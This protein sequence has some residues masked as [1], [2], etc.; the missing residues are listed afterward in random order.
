MKILLITIGKTDEAYL[1]EGIARYVKRIRFY[2][3]FEL[4]TI[5]DPKN[6]KTL[7]IEQ[8]K[9]AEADL[10]LATI[11]NSD[12]LVL[13]DENGPNPDSRAFSGWL[14]KKILAG[15]KRIV[16]AIG[17]PYGF[18]EEVYARAQSKLSL[19][20]MTFSHQM[21]RL[22]FLE[23]LYRAL[24]ISKGEPYHHD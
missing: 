24:T 6:R 5:P 4:K 21:V 17:G 22:I 20:K 19:S 9:K 11:N 15:G 8:Q 2:L 14:D 10:I 18:S 23:Q 1:E 16:F 12:E 13:L 7:S 3:P